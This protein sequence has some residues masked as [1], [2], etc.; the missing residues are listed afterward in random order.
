MCGRY[1]IVTKIKEIE[2][3]FGVTAP[4]GFTFT[5]NTNVSAGEYAP[6]ITSEAPKTLQTLRFGLTPSWAK[7]QMLF[8]NARTEG[9]HNKEDNYNYTGAKGILEK[10]SFRKPIRSQR[11]VVLADCFIEGPKDLGLD[12]PYCFYLQSGQRPF[13]MAGVW[14]TWI[15]P[16]NQQT[17]HSFAVLTTA[18]NDLLRR[19][20]H[21]RSPLVLPGEWVKPWLDTDT[22]LTDIVSM[23]RP[24]SDE[25]FNAYPI[26][27]EI[28]NPAANG[29]QLLQP[30]G[31]RVS[32]E[33]RY[34]VQ[35][36]LELFGMGESRARKRKNK[37]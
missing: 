26:S 19:V 31:E 17:I 34:V 22:P 6:V 32:P 11:C 23:M 15:N 35:Q 37:K 27:T 16:T 24:P 10:P 8:I 13:A 18:A 12:K 25:L 9:D 5:P 28:K 20:G 1:G 4:A 33:Y 30:I 3:K 21:H 29:M 36:E 7:K 14:D 2:K